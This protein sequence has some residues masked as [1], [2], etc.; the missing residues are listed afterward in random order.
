MTYVAEY[1][2]ANYKDKVSKEKL[3]EYFG[4]T[5]T[6][7]YQTESGEEISTEQVKFAD[8]AKGVADE[9]GKKVKGYKIRVKG[10][11]VDFDIT[12]EILADTTIIVCY[13]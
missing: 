4:S 7:T 2:Y 5:L 13:E 3:A 6:V 8:V 11:L 10:E 1:A 9:N 12:T